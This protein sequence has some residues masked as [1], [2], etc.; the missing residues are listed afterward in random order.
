[1]FSVQ[2]ES[3]SHIKERIEEA[4][5]AVSTKILEKAWQSIQAAQKGFGLF[6]KLLLKSNL[7]LLKFHYIL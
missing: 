6:G 2:V 4:M 7:Y 3:I 5:E 1:M